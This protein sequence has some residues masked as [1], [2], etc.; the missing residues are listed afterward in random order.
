MADAI[1]PQDWKSLTENPISAQAVALYH[2][3]QAVFDHADGSSQTVFMKHEY[4]V[5]QATGEIPSEMDFQ[6]WLLAQHK[7]LRGNPDGVGPR[8]EAPP[9]RSQI[10]IKFD[11][12]VEDRTA[13]GKRLMD[14]CL[15]RG[16]D[17]HDCMLEVN[18]KL[19][20]ADKQRLHLSQ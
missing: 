10:D 11:K 13:M 18:Q 2:Q 17:P 12:M 1:C 19:D 8:V 9:P 14:G 7:T 20:A 6:K 4:E 16:G 5:G 3:A 15:D